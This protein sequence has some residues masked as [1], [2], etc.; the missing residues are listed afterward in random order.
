MHHAQGV[1]RGPVL[2]GACLAAL[3]V[4]RGLA[5]EP[6]PMGT[7]SGRVVDPDGRPVAGARIAVDARDTKTNSVATL[8]EAR[9]DSDGRFRLGPVEAVYRLR[10]PRPLRVEADGFVGPRVTFGTLTIFAGCDSDLG[11]IRIDRGRSFT[12]QVLDIDGKPRE[13]V[14]VS[15]ASMSFRSGHTSG[16]SMVSTRVAT[17]A[18]GR[19]RTPPLPVGHLILRVRVPDRQLANRSGRAIAPGGEDD[20]GTIRLEPDVPVAVVVKDEDGRPIAGLDVVY[21]TSTDAEGRTALRGFGRDFQAQIQARKAGY[22]L[23]NWVV[24]RTE[25]G[26]YWREVGGARTELG[27][28]GE[29]SMTLKRAGWIEGRAI[30][31]DTGAPV[32]LERVV[33]C[34]FERKPSGEVVLRGCRSDFEQTEPG[35]F[36]ATFPVPN[37]YHLTFTAQGYHDAEAYTPK[38]SELKT[39]EGIVAKMKK[40]TE[41]STPQVA[42]Q[43]IA[44]T[45]T[46]DGQ[47]VR[48]G[49]VALWALRTRPANAPNS[50]VMRQRTAVG[51]PVVAASVPIRDGS[52]SVDVPFQNEAWYV[53]AEEAGHPLTQ[54]GPLA[55]ALNQKKSLDIACTEGGRIRG[56]VKDVPPGWEGHM[57]VVAFSKTAVREETRANPDGTF[58][59]PPLPPGEYGL[60]VG[61]DA[62]EDAEVYFGERAR[63]HPEAFDQIADPW[64]RA[65]VVSIQAGQDTGGVE[66]EL[67][68]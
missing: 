18:E 47:P 34:N 26:L 61:H 40:K 36:R 28:F 25:K 39:I 63:E 33:V 46:R 1:M 56:R 48:S 2:L 59:L 49:W 10:L 7:L 35:R 65:R 32:R 24:R 41:D 51:E 19:F 62:Y 23:I 17:D 60:K 50:P 6:L 15:A 55:I 64:K 27:P 42:R 45:V 30:D 57:W 12:G 54:V 21:A 31:A 66:L 58:C 13:G 20:L 29:L 5:A 37:E 53:V 38:V 4:S 67:P 68:R 43:T 22:V 9:T 14:D 16:G 8:V 3:M 11:T 44:G 52:Y